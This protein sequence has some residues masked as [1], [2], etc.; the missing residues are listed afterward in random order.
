MP[1]PACS[2]LNRTVLIMTPPVLLVTTYLAYNGFVALFGFQW[3]YFLGFLFK[4]VFWCLLIPLWLVGSDGLRRMFRATHPPVWRP[5][6]L[7][8]LLLALPLIV[9]Y[10]YAF[11]RALPHATV[12]IVLTSVVIALVN[13]TLEE[14]LWRGTYVQMFPGQAIWAWLY[15]SLGFALWHIAPQSVTGGAATPGGTAAFVVVAGVFGLCWGRVAFR[16]GSIRW[17]VV[18]HVLLD[19]AGLGALVYVR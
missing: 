7:G 17:T 19:F 16:T 6:W 3:G 12:S 11:P 4:W 9:A 8:W 14:V 1:D 5:T 10:G 15:P 18:S 2:R 13:G